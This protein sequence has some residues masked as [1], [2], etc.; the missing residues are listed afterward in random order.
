MDRRKL[1][2]KKE[3]KGE[4]LAALVR[5]LH[6]E[7]PWSKCRDVIEKGRVLA[8]GEVVADP[9]RRFALSVEVQIR[10]QGSRPQSDVPDLRVYHHDAHLI[11]VEKPPGIE[12]VPF[13]TKKS[14]RPRKAPATLID[15]AR[16]WIEVVEEHKVPPLRVVHRIDK[17][18]S[19]ILVFA[20]TPA[21]EKSL[22]AQF[23]AHTIHRKYLAICLGE[24]RSGTIKSVLVTDRGD[25]YRG[26]THNKSIGKSAITHVKRLASTP[27]GYSLIECRLETGRTHQIRIHLCEAGHP[28]CGDSVYRRPARG[29]SDI[30]DTSSAPRLALH[31][32]E[33]GFQHPVTLKQV[34][35]ESTLPDD[36]QELWTRLGGTATIHIKE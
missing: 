29:D 8:G 25:G 2:E 16:R 3:I 30:P 6:P 31:A 12:S 36:L 32:A 21:A 27:S 28:L 34:Q 1:P 23:R 35:F 4:T 7:W 11:V 18:T 22:A 9:V 15:L 26:S 17:G 13:E 20:R 19:G 33:L 5:R 10:E 24:V 14:E